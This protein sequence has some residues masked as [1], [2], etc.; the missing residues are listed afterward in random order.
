[1]G[2]I[3]LREAGLRQSH[4]IPAALYPKRLKLEYATRAASGVV[5][6]QVK[7]PL[8]CPECERRFDQNGESEVLRWIAPKAVKRFPLHER[9]RLALPREV[10]D[11]SV[12]RFAGVEIG[13]NMDKFAYFALSVVWRSAAHKWV[14]PDGTVLRPV[15][16]GAFEEP[17]RTYL[18]GKAP[19]P[20][21]TAAIVIVC[22]D[23]VIVCSDKEARETWTTPSIHVEAMCL[24]FRFLVRGVFF[25]VMMGRHLPQYF[26]DRCC[27]SPRKCIFY[28]DMR[29]RMGEISRIFDSHGRSSS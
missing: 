8:L 27:T 26:R 2:S 14:L 15:R 11:H 29:H 17:I 7:D 6:E 12:S 19:L 10:E 22:S 3:T 24:N 18:L 16:I 21:D 4:F 5:K 28:G 25:R 13:L 9:L 1:M 20:L 23:I